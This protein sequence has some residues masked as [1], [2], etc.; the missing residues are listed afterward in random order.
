MKRILPIVTCLGLSI[1]PSFAADASASKPKTLTRIDDIRALGRSQVRQAPAVKVRGVVT[2]RDVSAPVPGW[3][4]L[5]DGAR[6][7]WVQIS[8]AM[9]KSL[10]KGDISQLSQ[11]SQ[12]DVL[13]LEGLVRPGDYAPIIVPT[14]VDKSGSEPLPEARKVPVERLLSGA[15]D[16][17]R[18]ELEGVI[19]EVRLPASDGDRITFAI[20]AREHIFQIV[21]EHWSGIDPAQ[22]IDAGVR[23]KGVFLP[24]SNIR[25]EMVALRLRIAG[26]EDI[27]VLKK[28]P[29]DP[30]SIPRVPLDR[31]QP[32]SPD[33]ISTHRCVTQGVVTFCSPGN[34]FFV[35]K[36][37]VGVKV[38]SPGTT[39][40]VGNHVEIAGFVDM[41]RQVASI[42]GAVVRN[43]GQEAVPEPVSASINQLLNPSR[44]V[45]WMRVEKSDF[46]GRLIKIRGKLHRFETNKSQDQVI[47]HMDMK[48]ATADAHLLG[49]APDQVDSLRHSWIEDADLELTGVC[50]MSFLDSSIPNV[51]KAAGFRLW[52][53]SPADVRVV[54]MPPWWTPQRLKIALLI[55]ILAFVSVIAWSLTLRRTLKIRTA[56]LEEVMSHHRNA[57]LEFQSAQQERR[58]L[59]GD[60][61]DGLQQMIAGVSYRLEAAIG[62]LEPDPAEARIQLNATRSALNATKTRLGEC[63]WGLRQVE[64]ESGD[65]T[66]LLRHVVDTS[67]HW[68][69]GVVSLVVAGEPLVLSR[70][71]M[72]SLLLL[73][74]EAVGNAL[75]HGHAQHVHVR[76][77]YAIDEIGMEIEDDGSGFNPRSAP[78][79][80]DGHYGLEGMRQRMTWLGGTVSIN[81]RPGSGTCIS[82]HLPLDKIHTQV[83]F[84]PDK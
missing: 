20:K 38:Q 80:R 2:L 24:I 76:L 78:G 37:D 28:P 72:G 34:F 14:H 65:F 46:D 16:C 57:E 69:E 44:P 8:A 67:Q 42:T 50:E 60:L 70:D 52:L 79:T 83:S 3:L 71:V 30:F 41:S 53:R 18:V 82:V 17:Q 66:T 63:L 62:Q 21:A 7:I 27:A 26:P 47:L 12:G 13:E 36:K 39:V 54:H 73:V 6:S 75:R 29:K 19:Q 10:F 31:L 49:L 22:L 84:S 23:V 74:Q 40:A 15:E 81:S 32:F 4:V 1:G 58:R 77:S 35:Q 51:P 64:E 5:D 9:E 11:I 59:A 43:L 56:R 61:H 25:S 48:D 55:S 68:P 45:L 33:G